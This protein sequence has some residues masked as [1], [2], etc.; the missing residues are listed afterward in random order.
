MYVRGP[1]RLRS[2]SVNR[3]HLSLLGLILTLAAAV[4]AYHL[5]DLGYWTDEFC[6]LSEADGHGLQLDAT[7]T[8]R[9]LP[10]LPVCT[11][12]ADARPV[13]AICPALAR[14]DTHPPLYFLLVRVWEA[15]FGDSE[16]AVRSLD[17]CFSVAAVGLLYAAAVPDVGR[18]AAL[19]ACLVM[20]VA[21]PQVQFAQEARNYAPVLAFALAAVVAARRVRRR[22]TAAAAAAFAACLLAM[23]LTHYYAAPLAAVL[24]AF[25][26]GTTRGRSMAHAAVATAVAATAF[27]LLWGP[28][29]LTQLPV[30][31][32]GDMAWLTD[33]AAGHVQRALVA[34]CKLPVRWV[35]DV[36]APA[37][38]AGGVLFVLLPWAFVVRA[39]L[40]LWVLWVV[41]P[42]AVVAGG[43]LLHGTTQLTL[44][45]YTLFATPGA[46]VLV[47][48]AGRRVGWVVPVT[49]VVA[50]LVAL[51]AAYAPPFKVDFRTPVEI[52]ARRLGPG[53]GLVISGPDGVTARMMLVAFQH[54][55]PT[56][57]TTVAV[58][59]RPADRPTLA[60]LAACP[61]VSV[62][63]LWPD[64]RPITAFL[65]RYR[66]EDAGR[67]PHF[68][69]LA[70]GRLG[71]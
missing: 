64:D 70:V 56:M 36:S 41:V 27:L 5:S 11:R 45:R 21:S 57:P 19:W 62:V 32:H 35:A 52:V 61:R 22:P 40:R 33:P 8:D 49:A 42:T 12:S 29:V 68:G 13:A 55:L 65:P 71:R 14:Q 43:D 63:W 25:A 54:Y 26:A 39:E 28:A 10:P 53:D 24:V 6:T 51:P 7:P 17:V 23:V 18:A 30:F 44:L 38:A 9:L 4:R 47:A 48:A 31:R 66:A 2:R 3:A 46:Y 58:L 16:A 37:A 59:T 15:G 50:G 60:A 20:A 67:V 34:L 1:F 69:R